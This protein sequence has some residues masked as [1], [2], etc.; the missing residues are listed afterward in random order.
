ML[1]RYFHNKGN[2]LRYFVITLT[3]Y[4]ATFHEFIKWALHYEN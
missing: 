2:K 3:I 1:F 4:S